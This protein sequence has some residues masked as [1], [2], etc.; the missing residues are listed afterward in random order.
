MINGYDFLIYYSLSELVSGAEFVLLSFTVTPEM[1]SLVPA[2][3]LV[4]QGLEQSSLVGDGVLADVN[5]NLFQGLLDDGWHLLPVHC[6]Q[7]KRT[8]RH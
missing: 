4:E 8:F 7:T 5:V 1:M 3:D 6:R 2:N